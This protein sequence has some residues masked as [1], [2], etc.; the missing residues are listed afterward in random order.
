MRT[1]SFGVLGPL[2]VQVDGREIAPPGKIARRMLAVLLLSADQPIG[3]DQLGAWTWGPQRVSRGALHTAVYRLRSWLADEAGPAVALVHGAGGYQLEFAP[4]GVDAVRFRVLAGRAADRVDGMRRVG[5]LEEAL[6]LWRGRVLPDLP[7]WTREHPEVAALER[8]RVA[9]LGSLA[10]AAVATGQQPS[11]ATFHQIERL[12][13]ELPYDETVQARWLM[14][15]AACGRRADA[16]RHYESVRQRLADDLGVD[17]SVV[18]RDAHLALLA[19][20]ETPAAGTRSAASAPHMLPRGVADFTGRSEEV[21]RLVALATTGDRAERIVVID[22]MAGVGKT[23]MAVHAAYQLSSEFPDGQ[24]FI[25]LQG[26]AEAAQPVGPGEALDRILRSLGVSGE[27]MPADV[28]DR[29]AL[30][31]SLLSDRRVLVVLDN[32]ASEAQIRP[33]LPAAPD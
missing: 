22:G 7:E 12:A 20:D 10:D 26:F 29:A 21:E 25:D 5:D 14:L 32:A 6:A 13:N 23:S 18:L 30:W 9:V 8:E 19:D 11:E 16:L 17:P 1:V 15:L 28:A 31:R 27:E 2:E 4:E 33:L 3:D 24:I